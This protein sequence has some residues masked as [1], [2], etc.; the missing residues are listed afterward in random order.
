MELRANGES[1]LLKAETAVVK[2]AGFM[3]GEIFVV[4][5]SSA[6]AGKPFTAM[7]KGAFVGFEGELADGITVTY[8][9]EAAYF[10]DD[11]ITNL[12]TG[13]VKIGHFV[14]NFGESMLLLK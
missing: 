12:K 11:K 8:G 5:A 4:P 13:A 3:H 14:T 10:K 7:Y 1:L 9:G 2:G 6:K